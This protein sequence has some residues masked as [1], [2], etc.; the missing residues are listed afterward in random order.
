MNGRILYYSD[1]IIIYFFLIF[2]GRYMSQTI[3]MREQESEHQ[4]KSFNVK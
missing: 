2:A 4:F 3:K 1:A